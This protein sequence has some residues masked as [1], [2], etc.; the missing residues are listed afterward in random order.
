MAKTPAEEE[1]EDVAVEME[2]ME[3]M[4]APE[5]EDRVD[6]NEEEVEEAML[7]QQHRPRYHHSRIQTGRPSCWRP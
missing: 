2:D 1:T 6:R 5:A 4:E 7:H 3:D